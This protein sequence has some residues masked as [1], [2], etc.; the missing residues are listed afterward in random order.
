M[1]IP[2]NYTI[3]KP[4]VFVLT[5][6]YAKVLK[7]GEGHKKVMWRHTNVKVSKIEGAP[8]I[9]LCLKFG[10]IPTINLFRLMELRETPSYEERVFG[11]I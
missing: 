8:M 11:E 7:N 5:P 6:I 3:L 1:T 2:P 9:P 10:A 4:T